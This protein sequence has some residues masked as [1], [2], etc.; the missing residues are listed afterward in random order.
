MNKESRRCLGCH[1]LCAECVEVCPNRANT[2]IRVANGFRDEWQIL[3]L[4]ALCN[5]CGN[6][7]TFCPW[8]GKPYGTSSLS[9]QPLRNYKRSTNPGFFLSSG[10]GLLRL[11]PSVREFVL[12][13]GGNVPGDIGDESVRAVMQ[14]VVKTHPY[15]FA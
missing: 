4:D 9:L 2:M 3:H 7:A 6:C 10:R 8:D 12:D 5:E 15:L 11:G 1:A 13:A 14:T